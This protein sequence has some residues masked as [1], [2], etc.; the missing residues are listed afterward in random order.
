M[1]GAQWFAFEVGVGHHQAPG[2]RVQSA[3][4]TGGHPKRHAGIPESM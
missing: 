3:N 1:D 2:A 4:A